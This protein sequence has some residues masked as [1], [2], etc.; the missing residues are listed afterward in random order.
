MVNK[1]RKSRVS[2]L[3]KIHIRKSYTKLNAG[4]FGVA[5]GLITGLFMVIVTIFGIYGYGLKH[6]AIVQSIYGFLGYSVS[7]L[8]VFLGLIYG[9]IVGFL[10]FWIMAL[11]YNW[12][13]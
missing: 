5:G 4:I 2:R 8:G 10:I 1:K 12:L 7:W 3:S 6:L 9:F 13:S 11:I